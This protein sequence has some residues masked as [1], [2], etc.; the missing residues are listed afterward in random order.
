MAYKKLCALFLCF[1]LFSGCKSPEQSL[2]LPKNPELKLA[3][4]TLLVSCGVRSEM[5]E[6]CYEKSKGLG[7]SDALLSS[8][9]LLYFLDGTDFP[10]EQAFTEE[11]NSLS[12]GRAKDQYWG[13]DLSQPWPYD[14]Y[15]VGLFNAFVSVACTTGEGIMSR[16]FSNMMS[17]PELDDLM[18]LLNYIHGYPEKFHH[19]YA[20]KNIALASEQ[21]LSFALSNS[22]YL[23]R[24]S[25]LYTISE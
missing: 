1:F 11:I 7:F 8:I 24:L 23:S 13:Y 16:C 4:K 17:T 9:R 14:Q 15:Y 18:R 5:L 22:D 2:V 12:L 20:A 21:L 19:D 10:G 3:L 25:G 6:R